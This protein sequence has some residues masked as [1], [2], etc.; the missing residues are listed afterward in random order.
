[1][2]AG[3]CVGLAGPTNIAAVGAGGAVVSAACIRLGRT[4]DTGAGIIRCTFAGT[5][6]EAGTA[7]RSATCAAGITAARNSCRTAVKT[8]TLTRAGDARAATHQ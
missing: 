2:D 5:I 3:A 7:P 8:G 1:V 6:R 4:W